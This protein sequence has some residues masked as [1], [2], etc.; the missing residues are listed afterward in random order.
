M[1]NLCAC[2]PMPNWD[3]IMTVINNL[4]R[5]HSNPNMQFSHSGGF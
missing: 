5:M 1:Q 3:D 4:T 2:V